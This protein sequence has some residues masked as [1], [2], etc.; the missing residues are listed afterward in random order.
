M[1]VMELKRKT[2]SII[3]KAISKIYIKACVNKRLND[4][5]RLKNDNN[6]GIS[7]Y[8]LYKTNNNT[9]YRERAKANA[10]S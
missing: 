3:V 10:P 9:K 1:D 7:L 8:L 6:I 5:L 4:T 2:A